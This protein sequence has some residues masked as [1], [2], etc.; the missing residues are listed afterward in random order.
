LDFGETMNFDEVIQLQVLKLK[1]SHGGKQSS[2]RSP[3]EQ[4]TPELRQ[5][6]A[7]VLPALIDRLDQV[8]QPAGLSKREFIEAAV[9]D[10]L[11][12]AEKRSAF[13]CP[14]SRE[15]V[16]LTLTGTIRAVTTLGG[17]VNKK[18]GE[19]IFRLDLCSRSRASTTVVWFNSSPSQFRTP[20]PL[21][22][23]LVNRCPCQCVPGLLARP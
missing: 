23:V 7:K 6:C 18:T 20:S 11:A 15:P 2:G 9:S 21:K 22:G 17:G 3:D 16:M 19:V 12:R 8:L 13:R 10:A 5:M 4:S 14:G 1:A